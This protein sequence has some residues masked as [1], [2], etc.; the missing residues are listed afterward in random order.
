ME[1]LALV[2]VGRLVY[3]SRFGPTALP[4]IYKMHG[5]SIVLA[6]WDPVI[7]ED[8]RT[9]IAHAEYQVAFE[10]DQIKLEARE[11]WVVLARGPAHHMDAEAE[12]AS[13]SDTGLETLVEGI[14]AHFV[15]VSPTQIWATAPAGHDASGALANAWTQTVRPPG[16]PAVSSH[17]GGAV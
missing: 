14:P 4:V 5:G 11:G 17:A 15:R 2:G 9:G 8:L 1:L 7:D 12:R 10:A 3:T 6:T 13:I 16:R